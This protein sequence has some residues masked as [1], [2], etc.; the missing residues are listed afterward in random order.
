MSSHWGRKTGRNPCGTCG[1]SGQ[2]KRITNPEWPAGDRP[3]VELTDEDCPNCLGTGKELPKDC[4]EAMTEAVADGLVQVQDVTGY[5]T[6]S[7]E[8]IVRNE[9]ITTEL[10]YCPWCR[11]QYASGL[12][13]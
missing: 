9:T 5:Y 2:R 6:I 13:L 3:Y 12:P 11:A 4:C 7:G 8:N 1:G 10:H